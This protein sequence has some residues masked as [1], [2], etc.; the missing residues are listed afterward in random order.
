MFF[1]IVLIAIGLAIL[2]NTLGLLNGSFWGFF[3]AL[4]FIIVGIK[5]MMKKEDCPMCGWHGLKGH[6]CDHN[7]E[8][9]KNQ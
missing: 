6:C 3:W 9:E 5:M 4:F 8:Q 7:H 2:L 1:A